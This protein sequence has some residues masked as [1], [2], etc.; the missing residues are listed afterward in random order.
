[1]K[2]LT[3]VELDRIFKRK[4]VIYHLKIFYLNLNSKWYTPR[5]FQDGIETNEFALSYELHTF[6]LLEV[7]ITPTWKHGRLVG[8]QWSFRKW[9]F[10]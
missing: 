5:R 2:K 9:R 6:G 1:M 3:A 7:K 10:E 4:R 8:Q